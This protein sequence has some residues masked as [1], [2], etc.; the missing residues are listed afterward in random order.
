MDRIVE[1]MQYLARTASKSQ[2]TLK[3]LALYYNTE[4]ITYLELLY[5]LLEEIKTNS[6]GLIYE[7]PARD[8]REVYEDTLHIISDDI[9]S[10]Q[11][12][13]SVLRNSYPD[14][15]P[16]KLRLKFDA[17]IFSLKKLFIQFNP[18]F[19]EDIPDPVIY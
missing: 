14:T 4:A 16:E 8:N 13:Y 5:A 3:S 2:E 9:D 19:P 11:D 12:Y 7:I 17:N 18:F 1:A 15:V 10:C 6:I